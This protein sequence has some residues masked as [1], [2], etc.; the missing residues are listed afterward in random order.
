MQAVA[1]DR[2][3]LLTP[4]I[5]FLIIEKLLI[6]IHIFSAGGKELYYFSSYTFAL[7][8]GVPKCR[9]K[10]NDLS[11]TNCMLGLGHALSS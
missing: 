8:L 5:N 7:M 2:H 6:H 1:F 4:H 9:E 3:S 10:T 11:R